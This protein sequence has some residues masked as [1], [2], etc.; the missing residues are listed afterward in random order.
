MGIGMTKIHHVKIPVTDLARSAA[1][2]ARLLD[3][4]PLREFV[5]QGALRGAALRSPEAGFSFARSDSGSVA[6]ASRTWPDLTLSRCTWPAARRWPTLRPTA[7]GSQSATAPYKTEAL[8]RRRWMCPTQTA[9]CCASSWNAR[10]RKPCA[11]P[12]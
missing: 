6:P 3:L 9:L 2:Y 8:T 12:A 11:S 7:T 5:E 4:V 10:T 1:W